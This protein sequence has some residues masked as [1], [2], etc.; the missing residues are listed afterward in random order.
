MTSLSRFIGEKR[1]RKN[2][3]LDAKLYTIVTNLVSKEGT[4][5]MNSQIW[6]AIKSNIDGFSR[7]LFAA[8]FLL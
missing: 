3:T 5:V 6:N 4:K 7:T 8:D 1:E 2:E